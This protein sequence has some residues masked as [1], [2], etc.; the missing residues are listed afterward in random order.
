V[1]I[2]LI[3]GIFLGL[4][5]I[6]SW[7]NTSCEQEVNSRL[8]QLNWLYRPIVRQNTL[9]LLTLINQKKLTYG[10]ASLF[11]KN[12]LRR[13]NNNENWLNG[14]TNAYIAQVKEVHKTQACKNYTGE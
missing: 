13:F 12:K 3:T 2:L 11:I 10:S 1:R 14:V 9:Q 4:L 7:K 6:P 8:G 5:N